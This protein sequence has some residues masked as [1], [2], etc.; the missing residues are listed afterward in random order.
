MTAKKTGVQAPD[1]AIYSTVTDGA[2]NLTTVAGTVATNIPKDSGVTAPDGSR[3]ITITDG[4][5]TLL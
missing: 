1:G 2:G 4:A 3:Y 5:G